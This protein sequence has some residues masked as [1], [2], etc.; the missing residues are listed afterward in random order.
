VI[1][2]FGQFDPINTVITLSENTLSRFLCV[3][4]VFICDCRKWLFGSTSFKKVEHPIIC[5]PLAGVWEDKA[6]C[7]PIVSG[8]NQ[9]NTLLNDSNM[10]VE[11]T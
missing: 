10:W 3:S 9:L 11:C 7:D 4:E 1:W 6:Q 5:S 2:D 8:L